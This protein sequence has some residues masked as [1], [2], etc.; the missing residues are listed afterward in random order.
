MTAEALCLFE[1]S[2]L[3]DW[4]DEDIAFLDRPELGFCVHQAF[5]GARVS[6]LLDLLGGEPFHWL[7]QDVKVEVCLLLLKLF[8]DWLRMSLALR[9]LHAD[10][11][12]D[13]HLL[14]E[15]FI[16]FDS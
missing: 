8:F 9:G 4:A 2:L 1:R 3:A 5:G 6:L 14:R 16:L 12:L 11:R 15:T 10:W 7:H 13:S